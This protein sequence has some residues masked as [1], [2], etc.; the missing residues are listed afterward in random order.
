MSDDYT[1]ADHIYQQGLDLAKEEAAETKL[2][3]HEREQMLIAK[4]RQVVMAQQAKAYAQIKEAQ[5]LLAERRATERAAH[6]VGGNPIMAGRIV[7][8]GL[9]AEKFGEM[10][11]LLRD[12][13][14]QIARQSMHI[15]Q[16]L[17]ELAGRTAS[18]D[19]NAD[20]VARKEAVLRRQRVLINLMEPIVRVRCEETSEHVEWDACKAALK[21]YEELDRHD[22][23]QAAADPNAVGHAEVRHLADCQDEWAPG[24]AGGQ[25]TGPSWRS[26]NRA[27]SDGIVRRGEI[28]FKY[29]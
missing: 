8:F 4:E 13:E 16:L 19:E 14:E 27:A 18:V 9:P 15:E 22:Q 21:A 6:T 7:G 28:I 20:L 1:H 10:V 26:E 5:C 2:A 23:G 24:V 12:K 29:I 11:Q 25:P 3:Q 17:R